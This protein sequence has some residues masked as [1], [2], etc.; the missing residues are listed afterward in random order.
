[1]VGL[2]RFPR[3]LPLLFCSGLFSLTIFQQQV[4]AQGVCCRVC[5]DTDGTPGPFAFSALGDCTDLVPIGFFCPARDVPVETCGSTVCDVCAIDIPGAPPGQTFPVGRFEK[6]DVEATAERLSDAV[7]EYVRT[8]GTGL[9]DLNC[10]RPPANAIP[11]CGQILPTILENQRRVL[12]NF[13]TAV[14]ALVAVIGEEEGSG[15][16]CI[17]E[18]VGIEGNQCFFRSE[19][20]D[21]KVRRVLEDMNRK[22]TKVRRELRFDELNEDL[23]NWEDGNTRDTNNTDCPSKYHSSMCERYLLSLMMIN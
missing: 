16:A 13:N 19:N 17:Q 4:K 8:F 18:K 14:R 12:R 15:I 6:V 9:N 2:F 23:F 3:S 20:A 11:G 22:L 5:A 10:N 1:M 7:A 21:D